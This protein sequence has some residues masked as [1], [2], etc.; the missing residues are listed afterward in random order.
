MESGFRI[1]KLEFIMIHFSIWSNDEKTI[2]TPLSLF[3]RIKRV[4][5]IIIIII[6]III[7]QNETIDL[8]RKGRNSGTKY[9]RP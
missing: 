3:R 1:I 5:I 2:I 7:K 6:I 9:A 8:T 4:K